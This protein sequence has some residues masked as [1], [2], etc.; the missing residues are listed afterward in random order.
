M[1]DLNVHL[2]L[3]KCAVEHPTKDASP[4][5][6][7]RPKDLNV[8]LSLLKCAVTQNTTLSAL[9]CAVTKTSPA[10]PLE[11]AVP[12]KTGGGGY[13]VLRLADV[14]TILCRSYA[15]SRMASAS[16]VISTRSPTTIPPRS[17]T[18]FQL[19]P[20]SWRLIVVVA[21]K[22][23]RVLGPWS[24]PFSHQGVCHWPR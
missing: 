20:K 2:S 18:E 23:A 22:P 11:C 19:A 7:S 9:E 24:A 16:M 10:S 6:A 17:S 3:L 8:H 5:G 1:K 21:R 15:A 12:K 14:Q 4:E 13:A